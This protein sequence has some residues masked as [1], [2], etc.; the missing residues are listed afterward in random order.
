M[1]IIESILN[2]SSIP[3]V[4][5]SMEDFVASFFLLLIIIVIISGYI[6]FIYIINPIFT[7]SPSLDGTTRP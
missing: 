4:V 6:L 2:Y 3:S 5:I 1:R 7:V